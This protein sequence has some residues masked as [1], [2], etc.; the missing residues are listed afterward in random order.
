MVTG[1]YDSKVFDKFFEV[2]FGLQMSCDS[3]V[4]QIV[5]VD[6]IFSNLVGC[7]INGK[8]P[9]VESPL[10]KRK[11]YRYRKLNWRRKVEQ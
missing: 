9:D 5:F 1:V 4:A 11:I 3:S 8:W 7:Q 6:V 10:Q 2:H